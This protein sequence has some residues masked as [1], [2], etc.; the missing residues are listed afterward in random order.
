MQFLAR[1]SK[2]NSP[3]LADV[4][5]NIALTAVNLEQRLLD[6]DISPDRVRKRPSQTIDPPEQSATIP[7]R[8]PDGSPVNLSRFNKLQLV[9]DK[10]P[11]S[12]PVRIVTTP[13]AVRPH[14]ASGSGN[15]S[16]LAVYSP[17]KGSGSPDKP[18]GDASSGRPD[19]RAADV[20]GE[21]VSAPVETSDMPMAPP[22]TT[23]DAAVMET[24]EC[25]PFAVSTPTT[26]Y[27]QTWCL[28]I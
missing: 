27:L 19:P 22:V 24:D 1:S 13:P 8:E 28:V 25:L 11:F 15:A 21:A 6:V 14:G 7:L 16:I 10:V 4:G 20:S 12:S 2:S 18:S 26:R 5:P 17:E 9:I 23:P 3:A